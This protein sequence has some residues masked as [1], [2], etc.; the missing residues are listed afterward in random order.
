MAIKMNK[1]QLYSVDLIWVSE[2]QGIVH[3]PAVRQSISVTMPPEFGGNSDEWNPELL[4]LSAVTCCYM[5]TYLQFVK[6]IKFGNIGL[7]CT[8]TGQVELIEGKYKFTFIHI[9]PKASVTNE[10]DEEK[11]LLA[12]ENAKRY[13]LISN[14]INA[15]ILHHPEVV[16]KNKDSKYAA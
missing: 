3:S 9:Y 1:P 16:I 7:E 2:D 10:L 11:A 14:S 13:C 12:M 4:F 6:K 5:S 15:E 8:A